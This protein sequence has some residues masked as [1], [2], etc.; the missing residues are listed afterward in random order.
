[1][2][3]KIGII[4]NNENFIKRF[5][6]PRGLKVGKVVYA[7]ARLQRHIGRYLEDF[8]KTKDDLIRT[9]GDKT[10]NPQGEEMFNIPMTEPAIT[11]A[12]TPDE[13]ETTKTA[14]EDIQKRRGGFFKEIN[15][16]MNE[17]IEFSFDPFDMEVLEDSTFPILD[18]QGKVTEYTPLEPSELNIAISIGFVNDFDDF[19]EKEEE[20]P[21]DESTPESKE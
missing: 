7:M 13:T 11:D 1:M 2:Q 12:M 9:Y 17:D 16:L 20:V 3:T 4:A 21:E 6:N 10:L 18:E 8:N 15:E 19:I 5:L 14:I